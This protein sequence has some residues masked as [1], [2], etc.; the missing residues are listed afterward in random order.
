MPPFAVRKYIVKIRVSA[1]YFEI[2][3]NKFQNYGK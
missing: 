1:Q 3:A 2:M